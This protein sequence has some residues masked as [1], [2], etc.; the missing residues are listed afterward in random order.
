MADENPTHT[1][2]LPNHY[3][4]I[5]QLTRSVDRLEALQQRQQQYQQQRPGRLLE[6]RVGRWL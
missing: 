5:A 2:Q 1:A 4:A 3:D 6:H